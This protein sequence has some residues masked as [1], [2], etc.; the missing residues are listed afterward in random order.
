MSPE[1][2]ATLRRGFEL[3]RFVWSDVLPRFAGVQAKD[4]E[5]ELEELKE[6]LLDLK[7]AVIDVNPSLAATYSDE[8]LG[9]AGKLMDRWSEEQSDAL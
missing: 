2:G 6:A 4:I 8:V 3:Y 5:Y 7:Q 9:L 1:E